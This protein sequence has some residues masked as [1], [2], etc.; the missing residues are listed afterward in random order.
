MSFITNFAEG[1]QAIRTSLMDN[2]LINDPENYNKL[3]G[4]ISY[5]L[6]PSLNSGTIETIQQSTSNAGQYRPVEVKYQPHWG[7]EDVLTND[8]G[9]SCDPG[10]QRRWQIDTYQADQF[11]YNSF[12]LDVNYL[13]QVLEDGESIRGSALEQGILKSMRLCRE[14]MDSQSLA[15]LTAQI[16]TNPAQ[17]APAGAFTPV[18]ML[19]TDGGADVVNFD[20]IT[21]DLEENF[22][23][24][25][26]GIIGQGG[27]SNSNKYFNRLAVGNLNTNA[28][29]DI[30][31][32]ASQFGMLYFKDQ[33]TKTVLGDPNRVLAIAPGLTQL[34]GFNLYRSSDL[35]IQ[36]ADNVMQMIMPDPIYPIDWDVQIRYDQN[37]TAS[38]GL[39]GVWKIEVFKYF[40]IFTTPTE[41]F[42]GVYSDLN[43][44]NGIVG[45]NITSA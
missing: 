34:Y 25:P 37:C 41:A 10:T 27:N 20:F 15:I 11:V 21:N 16:G 12:T 14:S 13:M 18:Q 23:N 6:N 45:Y 35:A 44:F 38:N 3:T 36:S 40:G 5:L 8:A 17:G 24:G 31:E 43:G 26:V 29:V 7:D 32:V 42:G 39:Q 28:G 9:V 19:N 22:M 33:A 30:R 4:T 1:L 2:T